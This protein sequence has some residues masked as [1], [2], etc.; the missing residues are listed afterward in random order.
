MKY[1]KT[2]DFSEREKMKKWLVQLTCATTVMLL[3]VLVIATL[4][5]RDKVLA[6][7]TLKDAQK[8]N[9]SS[10]GMLDEVERLV[11]A[12]FE[13]KQVVLKRLEVLKGT[14]MEEAIEPIARAA[15]FYGVDVSWF[16]GVAFAESSFNN[17]RN[18]NPWGIMTASGLRKYSSWEE[19][20][21]SFAFLIRYS[22][23]DKGLDSPEKVMPRYVGY[24]DNNWLLAVK[25]FINY[26]R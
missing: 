19:S 16:L 4:N 23:L 22:Y 10:K 8:V 26:D 9:E 2:S 3:A 6:I 25:S 21:N 24:E 15:E 12:E 17:Y 1:K 18:L 13:A 11:G 20:V 14:G 7:E 5:H